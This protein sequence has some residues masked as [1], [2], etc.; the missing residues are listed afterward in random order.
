MVTTVVK[1]KKTLI[2]N[3]NS[4]IEKCSKGEKFYDPFR[5]TV[6]F[7]KIS[8]AL[9]TAGGGVWTA[10]SQNQI[11]ATLTVISGMSTAGIEVM[12]KEVQASRRRYHYLYFFNAYNH[13]KSDVNLETTIGEHEYQKYNERLEELKLKEIKERQEI[14]LDQ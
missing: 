1:Y 8:A 4:E 6:K 13:L 5:W 12:Q 3:V 7:L 10:T 9:L 11:A 2:D 14:D